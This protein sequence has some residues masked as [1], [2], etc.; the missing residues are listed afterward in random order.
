MF[1]VEY[2]LEHNRRCKRVDFYKWARAKHYPLP[3]PERLSERLANSTIVSITS[4]EQDEYCLSD[5]A[6]EQ[7][8]FSKLEYEDAQ[9]KCCSLIE[10]SVRDATGLRTHAKSNPC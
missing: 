5:A 9:Q 6:V 3:P 2:L 4:A 8:E 7:I 10:K 1:L